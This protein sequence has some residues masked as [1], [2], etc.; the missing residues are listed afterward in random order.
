MAQSPDRG[1]DDEGRVIHGDMA[2]I[3]GRPKSYALMWLLVIVAGG[4][5]VVTFY[6]VLVLVL[7]VPD[8][9][10][11]T[12]VVGFAAV[13]LALAHYTG[14]QA[15]QATNPRNP[16]GAVT[17]GWVAFVIW[18]LL[19]GIAFVVRFV[20]SETGG[21]GTTTFLVEG[22]AQKT[23]NDSAQS[24]SQH[25]AALLFLVLYIATGTVAA[26][27]G[28]FRQDPAAKQYQ[29]AVDRRHDASRRVADTRSRLGQAD[30]TRTSI[31]RA[32]ERREQS[33]QLAQEQCNDAAVRLKQEA[34]LLVRTARE[35]AEELH[36]ATN[37]IPGPRQGFTPERWPSNSATDRQPPALDESDTVAIDTSGIGGATQEIPRNLE[38]HQP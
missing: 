18:A 20:I 1:S 8:A 9:L 7:N 25:L 37:Y 19:G 2:Q 26:L 10:V 11:W 22:Q 5:D 34:R 24:T 17:A 12:S 27:Q 32:R 16:P 15:R 30:Q 4:V 28:F 14:L 38:G 21:A 13:A 29:R 3:A 36:R 33:W 23:L 6:Q 31:T 35:R